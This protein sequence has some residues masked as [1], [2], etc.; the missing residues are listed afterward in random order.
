MSKFAT[1][2]KH[3]NESEKESLRTATSLSID[4]Y[5]DTNMPPPPQLGGHYLH[6]DTIDAAGQASSSSLNVAAAIPT[7]GMSHSATHPLKLTDNLNRRF[8]RGA[9]CGPTSLARTKSLFSHQHQL[10]QNSICLTDYSASSFDETTATTTSSTS[11]TSGCVADEL[12]NG[13]NTSGS[14]GLAHHH[15][16]LSSSSS[17]SS[18]SLQLTPDEHRLKLLESNFNQISIGMFVYLNLFV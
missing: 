3:P 13:H 16:E 17:S 12:R 7:S 4:D 11:T 14:S 2:L 6:Q 10:Q 5:L 1:S 15:H 9:I 18:S 8:R